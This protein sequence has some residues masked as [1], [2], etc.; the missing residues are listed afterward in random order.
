MFWFTRTMCK[1]MM[2]YKMTF[3]QPSHQWF[4]MWWYWCCKKHI[5]SQ[6]WS[7]NKYKEM[8][9]KQLKNRCFYCVLGGSVWSVNY[10]CKYCIAKLCSLGRLYCCNLCLANHCSLGRFRWQVSLDWMCTGPV[11]VPNQ[12]LVRSIL[13]YTENVGPRICGGCLSGRKCIKCIFEGPFSGILL[14]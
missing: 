1:I 6:G 5:F 14:D 10:N 9:I 3:W 7:S 4:K 11:S 12:D 13:R 2:S 8:Y